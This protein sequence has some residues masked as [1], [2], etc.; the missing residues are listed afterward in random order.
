MGRGYRRWHEFAG[1]SEKDQ[2]FRP[3]CADRWRVLDQ[4]VQSFIRVKEAEQ[5]T[6]R[7]DVTAVQV[8]V[9]GDVH[10]EDQSYAR[11]KIESLLPLVP[12]PILSAHLVLGWEPNPAQPRRA[13]LEVGLNVNGVPVRAHV[14]ADGMREGADLLQERLRHRLVQ[15]QDRSR[16]R[17]RW[18]SVVPDLEGR[19]AAKPRPSV[20]GRWS[21]TETQEVVRRKTFALHPLTE[22]EAVYEM[23]LLDHDFYLYT[24]VETGAERVVCR[25]GERAHGI[26]VAPPV[27]SEFQAMERLELA[28]EPFVFYFDP[29]ARRGQ[30]L[31]RRFDGRYGLITSV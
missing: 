5:M 15:L 25:D 7:S 21:S 27:L 22:D 26:L 3:C 4:G 16:S 2:A 20:S 24:D 6:V 8:A 30:V 18:S 17:H 14:A 31:Y 10:D 13:H 19:S 11:G 23:D 9:R 12:A 28:G 29:T 1:R